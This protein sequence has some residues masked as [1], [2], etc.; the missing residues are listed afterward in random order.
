MKDFPICHT[1]N[2]IPADHGGTA[3]LS[4]LEGN[5]GQPTENEDSTS[6]SLR[7]FTSKNR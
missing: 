6:N 5:H 3:W 7:I 1:Y 2:G 4:L